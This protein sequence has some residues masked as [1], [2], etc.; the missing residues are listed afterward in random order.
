M[1]NNIY[2]LP[3][4]LLRNFIRDSFVKLNVPLTDAEICADVIITSDLRGIE[5]HGIGRLRYYYD[6]MVSGQHQSITKTDVIRENPTTAVIDG[7]HGLGMVIA[8]QAMQMAIDKARIYG[9]GSVAVRNSTHFGIA[10]YYPLMAVAE[11]MI[12]LTVTNARPAVCPTF[13]TQAMLGTNPIAFGAPTDEPF[14]FLYDAATPII[15]R[16]KIETLARQ[17]KKA[18]EGWLVDPKNQPLTDPN[19]ILIKL[20]QDEAALLPLGGIGESMGGHKGYGLA[21]MV[22]ILSASLQGGAFLHS[23]SGIGEDGSPQ[24][25]KV[26]H[27]FMAIDIES[28][29][30]LHDFKKTTGEILRELRNSRKAPGM[31]RIYTAGEKEYYREIEVRERGVEIVPN[32]QKDILFL[33]GRL[34]LDSYQFPF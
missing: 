22:E 34:G 13:G 4:D 8:R 28:F 6:R 10:G 33:K 3:V 14:P 11:G 18:L 29:T 17:E 9:M 15:Q 16:G 20:T 26:G 25:F 27:F 7:H 32:L 24:P 12:G 21:T 5:S 30:S 31:T 19:D 1:N 23:L 2:Y